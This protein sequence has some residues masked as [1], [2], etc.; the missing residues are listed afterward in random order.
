MNK[1]AGGQFGRIPGGTVELMQ[2]TVTSIREGVLPGLPSR[3]SSEVKAFTLEQVL[4]VVLRDWSENE[5]TSG[6]IEADIADLKS[7]VEFAASLAGDEINGDGLP[8][9]QA[10]LTGLLADWLENWN[11]PG[12]PGPPGPID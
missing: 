12:D 4:Q 11:A 6:L 9:Y 5:N 10:T 1:P 7:F 2:R 3:A 8:I